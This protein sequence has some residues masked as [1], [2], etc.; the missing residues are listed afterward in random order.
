MKDSRFFLPIVLAL[1]TVT[2]AL[3][4]AGVMLTLTQRVWPRP[5][6]GVVLVYE[7]DPERTP[8]ASSVDMNNL[9]A[10]INAR[11]NPQGWDRNGRVRLRADRRIEIGVFGEAPEKVQRIERLLRRI[12][13]LEFRILANNR[14]HKALIDRAQAENT[15]VLKDAEGNVEAWWVPV[16]VEEEK[17]LEEYLLYRRDDQDRRIRIP[18]PEREVTVRETVRDGRRTLEFLVVKDVF[19]VTGAYLTE[20]TPG[21]NQAGEP[22]VHFTLDWRGARLFGRLTASNLP[23]EVTGFHR[24]LGIILDGK[25][26]SAPRLKGMIHD[27]GVIEGSFTE[28][29]ADDLVHV[30]N[31]GPLSAAIR[32]VEKRKV[33]ADR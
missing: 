15:E 10:A 20:V 1:G 31:A 13:T 21:W 29:E 5:P 17:N 28:K 33:R 19:D 23:D 26:Y 14:D 12:G 7:V 25:L 8:D 9:V 16:Q 22:C 18:E 4:C 27:R 2:I 6:A 3:I 11:V 24:K 30:L 32:Q